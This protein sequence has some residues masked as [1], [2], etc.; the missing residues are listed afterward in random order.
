MGS[1]FT[2]SMDLSSL[3]SAAKAAAPK[4]AGFA[5]SA[6]AT[7][8]HPD[9]DPAKKNTLGKK[10][11][12]SFASADSPNPI[13][14]AVF[15]D[16]T[17]SMQSQPQIAADNLPG[18]YA[19]V[20]EKGYV[21]NPHIMFGAVGD[22]HGDSAPLQV[23]QYEADAKVLDWLQKI[24]M[25]G[26]GGG[27]LGSM[28]SHESYDLMMYFMANYVDLECNK[29]GK[30]GYLFLCADELPYPKLKKSVIQEVIGDTVES[31]VLFEDILAA[32]KKKYNF[33]YLLPKE[34]SHGNDDVV[35]DFWKKHL[36]E[37]FIHVDDLSDVSNIIAGLVGMCEGIDLDEVIEDITAL[38]GP[39]AAKS[40]STALA[41]YAG[42]KTIAK[43]GT[44][45]LPKSKSTGPDLL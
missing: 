25:E 4:T 42:S 44:G 20:K 1:G 8:V 24:Y 41:A 28:H 38:S 29:R 35:I 37:N 36:G 31:D 9:M 39:D 43:K 5:Y 6:T 11:R 33:F 14:I 3:R 19:L 40:A 16:V 22:A 17:G 2:T 12:E 10:I 34:A 23:G 32:I 7:A 13:P 18:L 45:S 21:A 15:T 27:G 30:K 26:G